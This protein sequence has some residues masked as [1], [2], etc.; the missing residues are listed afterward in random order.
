MNKRRWESEFCGFLL[1]GLR[2]KY[3]NRKPQNDICFPIVIIARLL[4][5]HSVYH[6]YAL[7]ALATAHPLSFS[8]FYFHIDV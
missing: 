4:T 7:F 5:C 3:I 8:C 2:S 1:V 6:V